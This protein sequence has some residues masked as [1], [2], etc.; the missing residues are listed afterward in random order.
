MMII[1]VNNVLFRIS[2]SSLQQCIYLYFDMDRQMSSFI[3]SMVVI[4]LQQVII[5]INTIV[6][7]DVVVLPAA[8]AA[9][10]A[11]YNFL[12][13]CLYLCLS[14]LNFFFS[15]IGIAINGFSSLLPNERYSHKHEVD[16]SI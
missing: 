2:S 16:E 6:I 3:G 11:K 10:T 15:C 1:S 5:I 8:A 13:R 9:A 14:R 4:F 7:V 12:A